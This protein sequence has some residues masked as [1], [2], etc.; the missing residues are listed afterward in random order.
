MSLPRTPSHWYA[1]RGLYAL[2]MLPAAWAYGWGRKIHVAS[3]K[4]QRPP[5]PVICIGNIVAG[6]SGK[7]PTARAVMA[8]AQSG[9][10]AHAPS[11]LTRGY[12][13][14]EAALLKHDAPVIIAADRMAGLR[15]AAAQGADL[16]IMDD[17]F[18]NPHLAATIN[19]VVIDGAAGFGNGCLIPAGPLREPLAAGFA[20][21]HAFVLIGADR[22]NVRAQL[23]A[24]KPV[25]TAQLAVDT[26][27]APDKAPRYLAFAGLGRPEKFRD[28]LVAHGYDV[29]HF[30]SYADHHPYSATDAAHLLALAEKYDAQLI[31]TEKDAMR[32]PAGFTAAVLPVR[33]QWDD[34]AAVLAFLRAGLPR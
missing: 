30:M 18:Q 28:T 19:I 8:L 1:P 29:A 9:K 13:G 14:D 10:I 17:G 27:H 6:G 31:T 16:V 11:F 5:L 23:P 15:R 32:L 3:S 26:A 12:G 2:A 22:H 34:A 24:G 21:A 25:F 7:T 20:R 33:L 4:P